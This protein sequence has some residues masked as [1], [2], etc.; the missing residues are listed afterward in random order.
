MTDKFRCFIWTQEVQL[1]I[2]KIVKHNEAHCG[3]INQTIY[4]C[5]QN[6]TTKMQESFSC[7]M[8]LH[9]SSNSV[10][11]CKQKVNLWPL[12]CLKHCLNCWSRCWWLYWKREKTEGSEAST[13]IPNLNLDWLDSYLIPVQCVWQALINFSMHTSHMHRPTIVTAGLGDWSTITAQ[14]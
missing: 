2:G 3:K 6:K 8:G 7:S 11:V 14:I 1:R 5:Q 4:F 10:D 13:T 9:V 12:L